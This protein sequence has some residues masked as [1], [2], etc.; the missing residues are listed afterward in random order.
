MVM[1]PTKEALVSS[2]EPKAAKGKNKKKKKQA[3]DEVFKFD[4]EPKFEPAQKSS[5]VPQEQ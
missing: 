3:N 1:R 5:T 2:A 4:E